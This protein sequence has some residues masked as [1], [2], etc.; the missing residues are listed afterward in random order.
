MSSHSMSAMAWREF[1]FVSCMSQ[2]CHVKKTRECSLA[3]HEMSTESTPNEPLTQAILLT[4]SLHLVSKFS[5][6]LISVAAP[7]PGARQG[8]RGPNYR[9]VWDGVRQGFSGGV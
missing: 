1:C 4:S 7:P 6:T 2:M 5:A 9:V 3:S 8:F